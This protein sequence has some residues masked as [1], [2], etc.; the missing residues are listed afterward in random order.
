MDFKYISEEQK[1][2]VESEAKYKLINGCAGSH[3]TD[4]LIK[5]AILDLKKNKRPILFLTL[6]GSVTFE[7][8]SRLE[9]YLKIEI[10]KWGYSNHYVGH[11]RDIPVCISNYDAWVHLMLSQTRDLSDIADVFS[12]KIDMLLEET[13]G[14][15]SCI[16]KTKAKV[17]LLIIDEAQD[18]RSKKMEIIVNMAKTNKNT[19]IF[20]AGDYLQTLFTEETSSLSSLDAHAM[21]IFKRLENYAYFNLNKCMRC[22]KAHV[23]F[24]NL[25]MSKIQSK[26]GIP[27]M[28]SKSKNIID[29]PLLFTHQ[30][31]SNNIKA[32]ENAEQVTAMIKTLMKLDCTV[33]P[34]DIAIIMGKSNGNEVFSQLQDT[35]PKMYKSIGKN[36][37]LV[38]YMS[39]AGDGRHI[40][41][42]WS[43][44]NG[45]TIMLSIHGDKG[46]GHRVVVLLGLTEYSIPKKHHLYTPNEII[47][48]S[49]LN[50]GLTR[51][52]EYLFVGF[53]SGFPSR[54]LH[55]YHESLFNHAYCSW[56]SSVD[57]PEPYYSIL[58][59]LRKSCLQPFWNGP[60][61]NEKVITGTKSKLEVREDLSKGFAQAQ[62]FINFNWNQMKTEVEFGSRQTIKC[63]LHEDQY[64]LLGKNNKF[65]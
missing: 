5:C 47:S 28:L 26:Y 64:C 60:Y 36:P 41:L 4:T 10:N 25:L 2:I 50:V 58:S 54:Y 17:G 11:Y 14:P 16:L 31:T 20:I 56:D 65:I 24:N 30:K 51:S 61:I 57:V 1:L 27:V 32:R 8:K 48:E 35:L 38:N 44:A 55:A 12:L 29:K 7:I 52:T 37:D 23:D 18:L 49:M 3:K 9:K 39:T 43:Q 6:V 33:V 59:E 13:H 21:N 19:D 42:D 62:D 22:P 34:G 53:T 15:I 45:K 40:T 63:T 46:K